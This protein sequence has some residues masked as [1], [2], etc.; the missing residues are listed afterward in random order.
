VTR[1]DVLRFIELHRDTR[2]VKEIIPV[3][4]M[5]KTIAERMSQ[6]IKVAAH[7]SVTIE[8]D[9]SRMVS[10][11]QRINA[12]SKAERKNEVSFTDILVKAVATALKEDPILNSTL[13]G[14]RLKVFEDVNIGVAV[15]VETDKTSRL[16]V[17]VVRRANEKSLT[18]ISE[19]L[20]SLIEQARRS[21]LSHEDLTGGTFTITNLGMYRIETFQPIINPPETAILGVGS[22]IKKP[23]LSE[24]KV[25][26]RP[27]MHLTLSFDHRVVNGAP[28]ARFMQRLKQILEE[29]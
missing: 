8:V 7:C 18:E 12:K 29:E 13:E 17:P 26:V 10:L 15:D 11:R 9:A 28:A 21:K 16:L 25:K 24:Q 27:L 2:A 3:T 5:Q 6:S 14:D 20:R 19:E 22:I 23:F 4:G 1:E